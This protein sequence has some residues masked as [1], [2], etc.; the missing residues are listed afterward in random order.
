MQ[1]RTSLSG[2]ERERLLAHYV[3]AALNGSSGYRGMCELKLPI[4]VFLRFALAAQAVVP[5]EKGKHGPVPIAS[6]AVRAC[7][8]EQKGA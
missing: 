2:S 7:S 3:E 6:F 1:Q 4:A 5:E 8:E